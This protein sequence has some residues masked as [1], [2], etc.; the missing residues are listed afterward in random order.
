SIGSGFH[1]SAAGGA[2]IIRLVELRRARLRDVRAH[3]VVV[4]QAV[5]GNRALKLRDCRLARSSDE[6]DAA[7]H[8]ESRKSHPTCEEQPVCLGKTLT[9]SPGEP[10]RLRCA[11]LTWLRV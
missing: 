3:V 5:P 11:G 6:Q 7:Q 9:V 1:R 4:G 8:A 10:G 2:Q